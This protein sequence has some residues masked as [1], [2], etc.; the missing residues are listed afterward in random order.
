[1]P[2]NKLHQNLIT[3][4]C[5]LSIIIRIE[6]LQ[7]WWFRRHQCKSFYSSQF[8]LASFLFRSIQSNRL[9]WIWTTKAN[10]LQFDYG[11][12]S[13]DWTFKCIYT[14][15]WQLV[16]WFYKQKLFFL[17][18]TYIWFGWQWVFPSCR[19]FLTSY[20]TNICN[21]FLKKCS[22]KNKITSPS[23][24]KNLLHTSFSSYITS[25]PRKKMFRT[26]NNKYEK[27]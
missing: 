18:H 11:L 17:W 16:T 25:F 27:K 13:K 2:E 14:K 4:K 10:K 3:P 15:C 19:W 7:L 20:N 6:F 12:P 21:N 24:K 23:K 9:G 1:M 8:C 5:S 26:I 22:Q